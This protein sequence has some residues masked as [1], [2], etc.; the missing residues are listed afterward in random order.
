[1][2]TPVVASD[3]LNIT[4]LVGKVTKM[5]IPREKKVYGSESTRRYCIYTDCGSTGIADR[6]GEKIAC[7]T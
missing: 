1:M 6:S 3:L 4:L 7:N 5:Q 2:K